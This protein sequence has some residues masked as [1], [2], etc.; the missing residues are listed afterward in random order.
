MSLKKNSKRSVQTKGVFPCKNVLYERSHFFVKGKWHLEK[1][2]QK[3]HY[4]LRKVNM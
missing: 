2:P 3:G 4:S 1:K